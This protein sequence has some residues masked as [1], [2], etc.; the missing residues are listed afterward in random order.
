MVLTGSVQS[1]RRDRQYAVSRGKA[2][3]APFTVAPQDPAAAGAVPT[4]GPP[5]WSR[6]QAL[7][8]LGGFGAGTAVALTGGCGWLGGRTAAKRHEP[9][10]L[11]PLLAGTRVLV[12]RYEAALLAAPQLAATLT[13]L[14]D[15]H[16]VHATELA[17]MIGAKPAPTHPGASGTT[18]GAAPVTPVGT[19]VSDLVAAETR[20]RDDATAACLGAPAGR[21]ALLGSIA[22]CRATHIEALR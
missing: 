20:G 6:R 7:A 12:D 1:G 21:A 17:R 2:A 4:G 15:D 16:R 5:R 10:A 9:D 18:A 3:T 22:A 11:E 14:R 13:P 8:R 19:L